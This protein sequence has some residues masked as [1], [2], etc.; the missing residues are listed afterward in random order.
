M[1]YFILRVEQTET[2]TT[3]FNTDHQINWTELEI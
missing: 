3:N 2:C 1:R